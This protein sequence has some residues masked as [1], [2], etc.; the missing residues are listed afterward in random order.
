MFEH[1]CD[2]CMK[3][4]GTRMNC[5]PAPTT[6]SFETLLRTE[7]YLTIVERIQRE[8]VKKTKYLIKSKM[9]HHTRQISM[10]NTKADIFAEYQRLKKLLQDIHGLASACSQPDGS[11]KSILKAPNPSNDIENSASAHAT[12]INGEK[13][14]FG[15]IRRMSRKSVGRPFEDDDDNAKDQPNLQQPNNQCISPVI[16][17][18]VDPNIPNRER[19][20]KQKHVEQPLRRSTRRRVEI[21]NFL[22]TEFWQ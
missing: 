18:N 17:V 1:E 16:Q 21:Q 2:A 4:N 15:R 12:N 13:D 9:K 5:A 14:L 6:F 10:A 8:I 7:L 20:I 11:L 19:K 3:N 22:K